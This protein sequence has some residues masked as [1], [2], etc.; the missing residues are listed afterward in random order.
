MGFPCSLEFI[1]HRYNYLA[2]IYPVFEIVFA[3]PRGIRAK[4]VK[5]LDLREGDTVLEVGCGTGRNLAH[6]VKAV[7]SSGR[8]YGVDCT[9]GML[10]R[11]RNLSRN[12]GWQNV[13]LLHQDAAEM[14]LPAPVDGVL[15]S[16]SYTVM[17]ESQMALAQAWKYLRA[18]RH[19]V[20]MD[21][22]LAH[23]W[24]GRLSQ[25]L[26]TWLSKATVL[27]DL[28]R[29]PWEDLKDLTSQVEMEEVNLGTYYICRAKKD[30]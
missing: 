11:A 20:I 5:R 18:H 21:G 28:D 24:L 14:L 10:T 6:L 17:P 1:R 15:F 25:P 8:V 3:L 22:K 30:H 26:V 12:K 13:V 7:G 23:G 9:E 29:Q 16:L 19:V 4:A 2:A 27:G